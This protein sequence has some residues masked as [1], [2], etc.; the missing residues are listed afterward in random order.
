MEPDTGLLLSCALRPELFSR[1]LQERLATEVVDWRGFTDKARED[2]ALP[3]VQRSLPIFGD[4][5]PAAVR[6]EVELGYQASAAQNLRLSATLIHLNTAWFVPQG[7]RYAVVKGIAIAER[8]FGGLAGRS[9][10]D[11]DVL[12]EQNAF[13]ATITHLIDAG[14][15]LCRPFDLPIDPGD[16]ARHIEALCD[17]NREITLRTP[18]GELIDVHKSLDLTGADFPTAALLGRTQTVRIAGKAI[19]TLSTTDLFVFICYH[20]SR[21][22]WTRLHWIA[23]IGQ[24]AAAP[25]F[26]REAVHGVAQRC[27]MEKLVAACLEMPALL[28]EAVEGGQPEHSSLAGRMAAECL[29]SLKPG[30]ESPMTTHHRRINDRGFRIGRWFEMTGE[31]WRQRKGIVRKLR[32]ATRSFTPSWQMYQTLP[33]PRGLRWL[34]VPLR[35]GTHL[36]TY[37]GLTR[38]AGLRPDW[39]IRARVRDGASPSQANNIADT[40]SELAAKAAKE[41]NPLGYRAADE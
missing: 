18:A 19:P 10:R 9:C 26:D 41:A 37:T 24:I 7:M 3:L 6:T 30:A 34:Y 4:R 40:A 38:I 29:A 14:F 39:R 36:V 1:G 15:R 5:L 27:G 32:A 28:A 31:E 2:L 25:D 11:L 17:L 23:D 20:H 21:H 33:L 16:H 35:I 13:A 8:F 22:N 12:V